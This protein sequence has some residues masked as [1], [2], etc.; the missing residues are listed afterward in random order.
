MNK[1]GR[2]H[3]EDGWESVGASGSMDQEA[4][5]NPVPRHARQCHWQL[6][7]VSRAG[8]SAANCRSIVVSDEG[9]A[10]DG[11]GRMPTELGASTAHR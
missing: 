2:L 10:E 1:G 3:A 8:A 5:I 6:C 4:P 11:T 9:A 7:F